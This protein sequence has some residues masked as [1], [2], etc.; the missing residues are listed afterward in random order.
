MTGKVDLYE[1]ERKF[2]KEA[3]NKLSAAFMRGIR[4]TANVSET[5][6]RLTKDK[7]PIMPSRESTV[8]DNYKKERLDRITFIAPSHIFKQHFGF[9]GSKK[10]GVRMR[11]EETDVL[12]IALDNSGVMEELA[13]NLTDLRA[14]EVVTAINFVRNVR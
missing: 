13:D 8:K 4:Q 2:G 5:G 7:K 11:L 12:N 9:E 14:E 10:N 1:L 6:T 3:A